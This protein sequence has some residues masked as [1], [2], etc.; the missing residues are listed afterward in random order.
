M[1][2]VGGKSILRSG[3]ALFQGTDTLEIDGSPGLRFRQDIQGQGTV[4]VTAPPGDTFDF[5]VDLNPGDRFAGR[6]GGD[7]GAGRHFVSYTVD[8]VAELKDGPMYI[9][10]YMVTPD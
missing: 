7:L 10:H 5:A 4:R 2:T 1:S 8:R 9:V 3:T 6:V